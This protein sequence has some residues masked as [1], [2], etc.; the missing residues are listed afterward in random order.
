MKVTAEKIN[1]REAKPRIGWILT[2]VST[3]LTVV[4]EARQIAKLGAEA[5]LPPGPSGGLTSG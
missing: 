5:D 2:M 3:K 1:N 4:M